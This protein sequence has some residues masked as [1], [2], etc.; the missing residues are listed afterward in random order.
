MDEKQNKWPH[1]KL[2]SYFHCGYVF[3]M[4][5]YSQMYP[6]KTIHPVYNLIFAA[7]TRYSYHP[8]GIE[9]II[10]HKVAAAILSGSWMYSAETSGLA[11]LGQADYEQPQHNTLT[12][13]LALA[14]ASL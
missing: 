9:L 14:L 8:S 6:A 11:R 3:G 13:A 5:Y 7:A 10:Y 1:L 4:S 12:P 2:M